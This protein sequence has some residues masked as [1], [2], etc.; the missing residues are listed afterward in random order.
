MNG[1][2]RQLRFGTVREDRWRVPTAIER[3]YEGFVPS[4]SLTWHCRNKMEYSFSE[5]Q[6]CNDLETDAKDGQIFG[7]G[8][9]HRGTVVG[10]GEPPTPTAGLFDP[11]GRVDAERREKVVRANGI[12]CVAPSQTARVLPVSGGAARATSNDGLLVNLVTT[13]RCSA[14]MRKGFVARA[15]AD[16]WGD[17]VGRHLAHCQ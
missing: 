9:K 7:L 3:C 16:L 15:F 8:F 13:L 2:P 14:W 10:R 12:A 17:R 6:L 5:I 1:R 11:L 4:R